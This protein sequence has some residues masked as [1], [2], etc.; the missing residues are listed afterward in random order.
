MGSAEEAGSADLSCRRRTADLPSQAII[1]PEER[2][3]RGSQGTV[4]RVGNFLIKVTF[5]AKF[6]AVVISYA[7]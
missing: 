3:G 2:S 6:A 1:G 4:A 5:N 7:Q